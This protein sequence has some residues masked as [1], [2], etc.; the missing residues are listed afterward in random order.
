MNGWI[1]GLCRFLDGVATFGLDADF[2][3]GFLLGDLAAGMGAVP[4]PGGWSETDQRE[5]WKEEKVASNEGC[6]LFE[7]MMGRII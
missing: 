5:F 6:S 2:A 4:G 7:R 3:F 1:V